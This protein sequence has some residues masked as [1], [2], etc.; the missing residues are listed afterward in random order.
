MKIAQYT[1]LMKKLTKIL[2]PLMKFL[3]PN[4]KEEQNVYEEIS[5]NMVANIMGLGN[6]AT[7][8]GIKAISSMQKQNPKKDTL[9]NDMAMFIVINT[10][11]IQVI[12]TT[13]IALR[14]SLG[15]LNPAEIIFPVWG[16]TIAAAISAIVAAKFL[17]KKW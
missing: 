6:A 15:S 14:T 17:M 5:M 8:L 1:S 12:P 10:A 4:I 16:A 2:R 13:V 7:P 9:S 3:F 11:S